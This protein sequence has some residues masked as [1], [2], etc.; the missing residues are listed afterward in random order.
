MKERMA[1]T[2]GGLLHGSL[3]V[4]T[5]AAKVKVFRYCHL[6]VE[7]DRGAY[8][9]TFW[10]RSHHVPGV[11]LCATHKTYLQ[12][13]EVHLR[14]SRRRKAFISAEAALRGAE[15]RAGVERGDRMLELHATLANNAVW[16]L[17]HPKFAGYQANH[18]N[19][20][21]H[22]LYERDYCTYNGILDR[23]KLAT[24]FISYF[25]R[26]FLQAMKCEVVVDG[27]ENWLN[28]LVYTRDRAI[29]PIHHLLL[30][31]FLDQNLGSFFSAVGRDGLESQKCEPAGRQKPQTIP[32]FV[33]AAFGAAPWPC[34]NPAS[35]H[36]QQ[37]VVTVCEIG[38]TQLHPRRPRGTFRCE[39]G[40]TYSR[41]GPDKTK[42]DRLRLDRYVNYGECWENTLREGLES[43]EK[44]KVISRRLHISPQ[45]LLKQMFRLGLTTEQGQK[46]TV[47]DRRRLLAKTLQQRCAIRRRKFLELRRENPELGR[48]ELQVAFNRDYAWFYKNDREWFKKHLPE[49]RARAKK[50]AK[51]VWAER[52]GALA[53][54]VRMEADKIRAL[55]GRPVRITETLMAH[56]L[57]VGHVWSKRAHILP[58]TC[59]A[60]REIAET[61]D[62]YAVRRVAWAASHF[63]SEG[64]SPPAWRV[65]LYAGLSG[66]AAKRPVV[67]AAVDEAVAFLKVQ[68]E[69]NYSERDAA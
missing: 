5:F 2:R 6:C 27:N 39:C 66:E 61:W 19:H 57:E 14:Y 26:D 58:L 46:T 42:A 47:V 68:M 44:I 52:D 54:A 48:S 30:L 10:H 53:A 9:E 33:E 25:S 13:T 41:V 51:S 69:L 29:H 23:R 67:E 60:L 16:L 8:G 31:Q 56:N 21:V 45:T 62:Q 11:A 1:G 7:V 36:F 20:Y 59:Q 3:G 4:N 24:D 55:S 38:P 34:L 17:Q 49:R 12:E 63:K 22:L 28:R 40:F 18:R 37:C 50:V 32:P 35:D 64:L 15:L 65:A 43:G